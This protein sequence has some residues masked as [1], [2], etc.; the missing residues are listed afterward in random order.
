MHA[1]LR[2]ARLRGAQI[3]FSYVDQGGVRREFSGNVS[4]RTMSGTFRDDK[5]Q[6]GNWSATKK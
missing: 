2:E 5:G 1:G 6:S 3:A 4:G